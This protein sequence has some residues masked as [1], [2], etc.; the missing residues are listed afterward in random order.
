MEVFNIEN[1]SFTYNGSL[2]KALDNVNLKVNSG[3]FILLIGQSGCGK[4]TLLRM[5]KK[6]I[7]PLG[8]RCGEIF[9]KGNKINDLDLRLSASKIGYISQDPDAQIVTDKVYSELAF[10]LENLGE[11]Q[12]VI[13]CK[14]AEMSSCFGL[15]DMFE[16]DTNSLSG[17]EKQILNLASVMAMNPEVILLD[18]PASMLDP[19]FACDFINVLKRLNEDFG[20]TI[21]IAEHHLSEIFPLADKVVYIENGSISAVNSPKEISKFL[22]GKEIE[23]TLPVPVRFF[24]ALSKNR[25]ECPLTIKDGRKLIN[26][27]NLNE[28]VFNYTENSNEVIISAKNINFRYEKHGK[29]ILN[30]CN[31]KINKGEFY[32]LL[33]ENG[34]G[35]TTFLNVLSG[36]LKPYRGKIKCNSKIGYLPQNPKN[37]FVK[38]T[39]EEDFKNVNNSYLELISDFNLE[40]YLK[41]HP[42]DLSGG[43]IQ[44]AAICKILLTSPEII[45]LDEPTKGLDNFSKIKLGKFL[46]SLCKKGMTIVIVSHDIEFT[47]EFA[48]RCGLL[49]NGGITCE[50]SVREF[51]GNNM[52]YTTSA[53][54]MT[55]GIIDNIITFDDIIRSLNG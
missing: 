20:T 41:S 26:E 7:S 9:F 46:K 31:L 16:R 42:Y 24:N 14:V 34:C 19:I 1:L 28:P 55:K 8:K 12:S 22:I 15:G 37:V 18:E 51:F 54:K 27:L 4:T 17:G 49:F 11:K 3:D 36:T 40:N 32:A 10:G 50:N 33:G 48:D 13:R 23:K 39:L 5:L 43:E 6:E 47:A 45:L 38:D 30:N 52:F 53:S 25:G 35:K 44:R 21:I 29:D 2:K